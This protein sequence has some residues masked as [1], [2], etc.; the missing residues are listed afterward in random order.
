MIDNLLVNDIP[1]FEDKSIIGDRQLILPYSLVTVLM[2]FFLKLR[3]A[4]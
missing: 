4:K 1:P 2:A 3:A